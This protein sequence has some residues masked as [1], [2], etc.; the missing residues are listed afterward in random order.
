M[1]PEPP[2]DRQGSRGSGPDLRLLVIGDSAA[3]GVGA[4]H[5]DEAL[6]GRLVAGLSRT[7]S[8]HW[9]LEAQTGATTRSTLTRLANI[10]LLSADI[11]V[12]SL[13]VNDVTSGIVLGKWID[14][15][16]RLRTMLRERFGARLIVVSGLPPMHLFPALPQ[17]LRWHLGLRALQFNE[18]LSKQIVT[19]P[20]SV[21]IAHDIAGDASSMAS[22][23]F[24]PGPRIYS[25]WAEKIVGQVLSAP[26]MA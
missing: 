12:T 13:G 8:I 23:G 10:S 26:S 15:Q 24:H 17:P 7:R 3:A 14:Q 19:E 11:V 9:R 6:L 1:L 22:D 2:G 4:A 5:Q 16:S 21:F 20:G 25:R 18:A